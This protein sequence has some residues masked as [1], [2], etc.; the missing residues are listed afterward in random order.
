M[1]GFR[2]SLQI[3]GGLT[4][5][6]DWAFDNLPFSPTVMNHTLNLDAVERWS[7]TNVSGFSHLFHIHD[8]QFCMTPR[9]GGSNPGVKA[10]ET[11]WKDTLFIGRNQTVTFIAK[12]DHFA[13]A[14]NPFMYHCHFSNHE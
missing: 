10:Y 9:T 3:T 4:G 13:S 1:P 8:I 14:T 6:T 5:S 2:F 11:G 12:F 7:I